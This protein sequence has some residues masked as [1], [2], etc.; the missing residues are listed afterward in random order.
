MGSYSFNLG[1]GI[2]CL[3]LPMAI[4]PFHPLDQYKDVFGAPKTDVHSHRFMGF[5]TIDLVATLLLALLLA[6]C[7]STGIVSTFSVLFLLSIPIHFLFGVKTELME[8]LGIF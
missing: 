1:L 6:Y 2:L 8:L 7:F 3:L 4:L 5:A